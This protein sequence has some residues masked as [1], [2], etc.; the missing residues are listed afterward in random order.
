MTNR[1]QIALG[2]KTEESFTKLLQSY[3]WW[4]HLC[5][6]GQGGAQPC[7]VIAMK[8]TCNA[9]IDVKH[10]VS[11]RF[12]FR[13]IEA[14]QHTSLQY[15]RFCGVQILGFAIYFEPIKEFR[16]LPYSVVEHCKNTKSIS[17]EDLDNIEE[18]FK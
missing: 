15:A 10:C 4:C 13:R 6:R 12:E 9:L 14:N 11:D 2:N 5:A 17:Y 18:V 8:G 16:W 3:G 7:D 1:T